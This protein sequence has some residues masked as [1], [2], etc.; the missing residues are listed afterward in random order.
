MTEQQACTLCGAGGHTAAQCNWNKA[1]GEHVPDA[2]FEAE[3]MT[4]WEEHG[5]YCR[6]GGGD[7]ERTFA[8]Q[9][10]RHL[11]PQLMAARAALAQPSPA[12]ALQASVDVAGN[13]FEIPV[14]GWGEPLPP[15]P[16]VECPHRC[17]S[18]YAKD[19]YGAGFIEGS[20]MCPDCDAAMPPKDIVQAGQVPQAW[21]DVQAERLRQIEAEGWTLEHDDQHKPSE[22]AQAA[23]AYLLHAFPREA[24]DRTY[25]ARLWPWISGFKPTDE[26]R[27]LER[28]LALGVAALER[29]DRAAAPAQGG[30]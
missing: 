28:G 8:F 4:W 30:E 26:R 24:F 9:A 17:G 6:S 13:R 22:L 14:Q 16:P 19:S 10:W 2:V 15:E 11:Y 1:D 25:A 29:F 5:Q 23:V 20:G 18:V 7:Y 27:D 3:F 21:L 12:P